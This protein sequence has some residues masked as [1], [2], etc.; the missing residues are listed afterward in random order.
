LGI[1]RSL[2][3]KLDRL[4]LER[5]YMGFIRP[6]LEYGDVVWDSPGESL[7]PLERVQMNAARVVVG[8]TARC[9]SEGLLK[10]TSWEPLAKRREFHKLC[11]MYKIANGKAPSYLSDLVPNLVQDRVGYN[12]RNRGNIDVPFARINLYANSFFPSTIKIWNDLPTTKKNLPSIEVFKADKKRSLPK[13]N[14]LYYF[15]GRLEAAIHACMRI[16]NSPLKAHLHNHLHV[17]ENP[18][19]ECV[20]GVDETP[21]HFFFDCPLFIVQRA[22]LVSDL[23]PYII[24]DVE[25]L[26]YGLPDHDHITN[27]HIF[28]AVHKYICETNRFN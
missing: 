15:G 26:L 11:L 3:Y 13:K 8:A 28:S 5:I 7:L 12:L 9:S 6:L 4:S 14:P 25:P 21:K 10:E 20:I 24:N 1:L 27:V 2:K 17:V 18:K 23:L 22:V 16:N 19:C